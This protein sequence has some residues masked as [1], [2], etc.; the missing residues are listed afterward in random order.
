MS[1]KNH[2][3][4]WE[5]INIQSCTQ[6]LGLNVSIVE[7]ERK[8]SVQ[9]STDWDCRISGEA[10]GKE[11]LE[12]DRITEHRERPPRECRRLSEGGCVAR[13]SFYFDLFDDV[14]NCQAFQ[15]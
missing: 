14:D 7:L 2:M 12:R 6:I 11:V 4:F 15:F 5:N 10:A 9:S 8:I 13:A 3:G 1:D